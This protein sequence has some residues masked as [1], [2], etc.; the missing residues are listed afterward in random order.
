MLCALPGM[1]A[2]MMRPVAIHAGRDAVRGDPERPEFLR[3]IP[4]VVGD[5]RLCRP[6]MGVPAVRS[7]TELMVMILPD[8]CS[9][10]IGATALIV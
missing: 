3:E 4:C 1:T 8:R 5:S 2:A 7:A 6:V 10:M 9:F